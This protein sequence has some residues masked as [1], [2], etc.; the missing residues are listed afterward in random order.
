MLLLLGQSSKEKEETRTKIA[1]FLIQHRADPD[2]K[3]NDGLTALDICP[4][5]KVKETVKRFIQDK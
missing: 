4:S 1:C 5:E 3:N 2:V